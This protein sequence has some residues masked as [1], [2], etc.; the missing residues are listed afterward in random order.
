MGLMVTALQQENFE[1]LKSVAL[2]LKVVFLIAATSAKRDGELQVQSVHK[3]YVSLSVCAEWKLGL[4]LLS[5][6]SDE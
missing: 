3:S 6:V 4:F 2:S 1:P 5:S